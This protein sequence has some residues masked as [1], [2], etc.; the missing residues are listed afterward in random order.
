MLFTLKNN[1]MKINLC[2]NYFLV[3]YRL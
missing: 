3:I 2:R 1:F